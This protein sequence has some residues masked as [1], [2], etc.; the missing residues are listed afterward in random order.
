MAKNNLGIGSV[1][2]YMYMTPYRQLVDTGG[3]TVRYPT[4]EGP[5]VWMPKLVIC[6]SP[7]SLTAKV[8]D[9]KVKRTAAS[10]D[11]FIFRLG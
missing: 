11:F 7:V 10:D 8:I 1:A 6:L 3:V 5:P 9:E 4:V 2:L